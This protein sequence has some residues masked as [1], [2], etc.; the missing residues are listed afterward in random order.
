MKN[1]L[2]TG[3][4]LGATTESVK[5]Y[6]NLTSSLAGKNIS[7]FSPLDTMQF[8]GSNEERFDRAKKSVETADL[9]IAEVSNASHG[10]G[11][12][13]MYANVLGKEVVFIS[14]ENTKISGLIKGAFPKSIFLTYRDGLSRSQ[15]D[16]ILK[17]LNNNSKVQ[18]KE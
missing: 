18:I 11:M 2:I 10:Q 1:I 5:F 9:I 13:L 7:I 6:E 14:K 8:K 4:V 12:E 3:S 16:T 15:V 17:Q